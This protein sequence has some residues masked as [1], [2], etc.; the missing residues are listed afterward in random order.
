MFRVVRGFNLRE[1]CD[2]MCSI[3]IRKTIFVFAI[4]VV[5]MQLFGCSG[6]GGDA[7]SPPPTVITWDDLTWDDGSNDPNTLWED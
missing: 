3:D 4:V 6:S 1:E 5:S 7:S 2:D